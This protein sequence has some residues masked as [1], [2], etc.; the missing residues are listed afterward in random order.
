[1]IQKKYYPELDALK[2]VAILFIILSHSFC[3]FPI[4]LRSNL[5]VLSHFACSFALCLFFICSGFLFRDDISWSVFFKKKGDRL[6]IPL[7]FFGYVNVALRLA[8]APLTR[9]HMGW[10][11]LLYPLTGQLYW[12]L[13][14][15]FLIMV[16]DKALRGFGLLKY[17]VAIALLILHEYILG[18]IALFTINRT[19]YFY[20][21]FVLGRI[22]YQHYENLYSWT[23][24]NKFILVLFLLIFC[25]AFLL[26]HTIYDW[27]NTPA[28]IG[29]YF[30]PL[31]ACGFLWVLFVL[32]EAYAESSLGIFH[33]FGRY[34]LQYYLNHMLVLLVAFYCGKMVFSYSN[35]YIVSLLSIFCLTVLI[36]FVM[37]RIEQRFPQKTSILFGLPTSYK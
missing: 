23:V 14:S 3:E 36:C 13:Y 29:K 24:K 27:D 34:S 33:Y 25:V 22:I 26:S 32:C 28:L 19:S 5:P 37:L 17:I 21:F 4:D 10:G 20:A 2:G 16:L 6:L 31:S 18:D 35:S 7:L 9:S 11:V 15:L 1:M 12:F 30:V 8:M